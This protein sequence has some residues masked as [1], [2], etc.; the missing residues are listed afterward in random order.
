MRRVLQVAV[1]AWALACSFVYVG[2]QAFTD[3]ALAKKSLD[4]TK[5]SWVEFGVTKSGQQVVKLSYFAVYKCTV[6]A[7]KY[8]FDKRTVDKT[9]SLPKCDPNN[10]FKIDSADAFMLPVAGVPKSFSVQLVYSDGT[11]SPVRTYEPCSFEDGGSCTRLVG[12][13]PVQPQAGTPPPHSA[14][15]NGTGL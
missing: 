14:N 5:A 11:L 9:F 15:G 1:A 10:P 12:E 4:A 8:S 3:V 13:T 2:A 6:K 7:I